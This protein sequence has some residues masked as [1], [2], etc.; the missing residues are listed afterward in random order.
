MK[1]IVIGGVA[2][3]MSAASKIKRTLY[4]AR[5]VV[6]ERGVNLSYGACGLPYFVGDEIKDIQKM[7]IRTQKQFE[8]MGIEVQIRHEVVNVIPD[9]K[10]VLV[11]NLETGDIF[12]D[13]YD[14][15]IVATGASPIIPPWP[16]VELDH[17]MTLST[18]E[19]GN[20]LKE[21]VMNESVEHVTIVGAG[22]IGIELAET[23]RGL[24]KHVTVIEFKNQILSHLDKELAYQLQEE[25]VGNGIQVR[26]GEKVVALS[27]ESRV[28]EVKTDKNSYQTDLV[29]V[30]IGVRPNTGFLHEAGIDCL[31][32]GAIRVD[33]RMQSSIEHI[34]AAGDCAS[35]YHRV[36]DSYDEYIP[37]GTNAN[38][39]GKMLGAIISGDSVKFQGTLGTSM[40]KVFNLEGA[41]TGLSESEAIQLGIKYKTATVKANNHASY[42]PNPKPIVAKLIVE[43]KTNI[44]IGAQLVGYTGAALRI[45]TFALAI[46]GRMTTDEV[47]WADF[48]Y[49][50]PFSSVWDVMHLACNAVK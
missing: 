28:Q 31:R 24:G 47:G 3:G 11:K 38:K 41:K 16:G 21:A 49:A 34:Y 26:L 50:P 15:L 19:D 18:L 36:K 33:K 42:Y 17:V 46:T 35:V 2:A 32:N 22:F 37:L 9:R 7:V 29:I 23:I 30:S 48:G 44:I 13:S 12:E 14:E 20:R 10:V 45:N 6:Y 5:V 25:L 8:S 40:I 1:V 43:E 4:S 27:G 39:Q